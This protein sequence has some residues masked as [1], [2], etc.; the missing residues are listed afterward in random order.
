MVFDDGIQI[1]STTSQ[2]S[3]D[4]FVLIP[5]TAGDN[6]ESPAVFALSTDPPTSSQ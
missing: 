3:F 5:E 2:G 6:V 1:V 4:M